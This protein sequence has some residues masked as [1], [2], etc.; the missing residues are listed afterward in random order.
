MIKIRLNRLI[1][2]QHLYHVPEIDKNNLCAEAIIP[3]EMLSE[4]NMFSLLNY[5]GFMKL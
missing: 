3:N 1:F 2:C 5:M 4:V